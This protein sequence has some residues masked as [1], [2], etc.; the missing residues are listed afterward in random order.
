MDFLTKY[1]KINVLTLHFEIKARS[2]IFSIV[3]T[4][5][6]LLIHI[7]CNERILHEG[8]FL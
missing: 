3:E 7:S 5:A 1:F 6:I 8:F 4:L 2:S